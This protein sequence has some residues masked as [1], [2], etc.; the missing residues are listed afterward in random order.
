MEYQATW[1]KSN[2]KFT[3]GITEP[4]KWSLPLTTIKQVV[5]HY[6]NTCN[7]RYLINNIYVR[8]LY[9]I[10]RFVATTL[11]LP[12][13]S[14]KIHNVNLKPWEERIRQ[15]SHKVAHYCKYNELQPPPIGFRCC[16]ALH[17][18]FDYCFNV[19]S[20]FGLGLFSMISAGRSCSLYNVMEAYYHVENIFPQRN[21]FDSLHTLDTAV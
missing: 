11:S 6:L 5:H 13:L 15:N 1:K 3:H 16:Q 17:S 9:T 2:C 21:E 4:N 12:E 8:E 14:S 19:S 20:I 10:T 18:S 7:L